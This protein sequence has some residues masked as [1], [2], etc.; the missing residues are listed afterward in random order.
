MRKNSN[1][2]K[3]TTD[4]KI[5]G[6]EMKH[7]KKSFLGYYNTC[8]NFVDNIDSNKDTS[9]PKTSLKFERLSKI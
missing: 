9:S 8:R 7:L 1:I 6:S 5:E 2:T 4:S 3:A